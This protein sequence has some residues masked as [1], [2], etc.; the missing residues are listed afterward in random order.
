[1]SE[2][3]VSRRRPSPASRPE[4]ESSRDPRENERLEEDR[5]NRRDVA[6]AARPSPNRSRIDSNESRELELI[7]REPLERCSE[8]DRRHHI[9][10]LKFEEPFQGW[11][12]VV[13]RRRLASL[14]WN[15]E[16]SSLPV[17]RERGRRRLSNRPAALATDGA[18][19]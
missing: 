3:N 19:H 14:F 1:M 9:N 4:R 17:R 2:R 15:L 10:L 6:V 12:P 7:E 13:F 11:R 16:P 5:D 8:L 18:T